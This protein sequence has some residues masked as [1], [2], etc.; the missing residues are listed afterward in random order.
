[1]FTAVADQREVI[2]VTILI[3]SVS[4]F[5]IRI[6]V[7]ADRSVGSLKMSSFWFPVFHF[8]PKPTFETCLIPKVSHNF[9]PQINLP[10][11]HLYKF[12]IHSIRFKANQMRGI[13]RDLP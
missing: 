11:H 2:N 10:V 6:Q 7:L 12:I 1:M 4:F 8:K 5:M 9:S 13:I 3:D